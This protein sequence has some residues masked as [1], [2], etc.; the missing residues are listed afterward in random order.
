MFMW[1]CVRWWYSA[2][3]AYAWRRAVV[4]R[5]AWCE[6]T[7][8]MGALVRSWFAPFKQTYT[9]GVKG[10]IGMHFR[11]AIDSLISRVIGFMV[12]SVLLLAGAVC[13]VF[14]F[15]TGLMFMLVWA[16]IPALPL[17]SLVLIVGGVG[18]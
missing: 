2:G 7:F 15:I 12:R 16:F 14:V 11:A 4:Q 18:A 1:L 8:S 3:W 9:G 6:S 10:S 13:S 5:L 17:V